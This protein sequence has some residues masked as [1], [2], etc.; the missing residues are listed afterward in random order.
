MSIAVT[1]IKIALTMAVADITGTLAP[2]GRWRDD[3]QGR[4]AA[5]AFELFTTKGYDATTGAEIARAA[6]LHERSFFR[7]FPDKRD[8]L[9]VNWADVIEQLRADA[10]AVPASAPPLD[11]V[12]AA[13]LRRCEQIVLNARF[14]RERHR[15]VAATPALNE[16]DRTK[17]EELAAVLTEV[18]FDRGQDEVTARLLPQAAVIVFRDAISRW[19][20]SDDT[21]ALPDVFVAGVR[22]L[23]ESLS[24]TPKG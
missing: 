13:L 3:P 2:M 14:A 19:A 23:T 17:H 20:E 12:L 22:R 4:L 5:A 18:L 16:R 11:V 1:D 24:Q 7:H 10:S 21:Q 6:G 15:L 9:F 8:V